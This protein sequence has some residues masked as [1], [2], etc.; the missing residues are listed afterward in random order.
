[1]P[2]GGGAFCGGGCCAIAA[3]VVM[4]AET[5]NRARTRDT[6]NIIRVTFLRLSSLQ[7]RSQ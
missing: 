2:G 4:N 6:L 7:P 3:P 1:M 5:A